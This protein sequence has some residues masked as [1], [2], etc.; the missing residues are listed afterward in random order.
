[1]PLCAKLIGASY[2]CYDDTIGIHAAVRLLSDQENHKVT[3]D[4]ISKR[5][6]YTH[7]PG[8]LHSLHSIE[9]GNVGDWRNNYLCCENWWRVE[10]YKSTVR[11]DNRMQHLV[12]GRCLSWLLFTIFDI[13]IY[14]QSKQEDSRQSSSITS[15]NSS[16]CKEPEGIT[17]SARSELQVNGVEETGS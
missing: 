5:N 15:A 12:S 1:M 4:P 7:T 14:K 13:E 6:F 3:P 11:N 16:L 17:R 8:Q 2:Q 9:Y 10:N